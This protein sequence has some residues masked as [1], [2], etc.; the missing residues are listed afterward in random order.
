MSSSSI[1]NKL[2]LNISDLTNNQTEEEDKSSPTSNHQ[3]K[4]LVAIPKEREIEADT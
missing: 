3:K 4:A 1:G 2:D